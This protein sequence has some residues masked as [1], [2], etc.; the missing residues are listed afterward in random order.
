MNRKTLATAL[1][2]VKEQEYQQKLEVA[3]KELEKNNILLC[4]ALAERDDLQE[5]LKQEQKRPVSFKEY[6]QRR[7]R[8]KGKDDD[9]R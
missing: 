6:W 7:K 1:L 8:K 5:R 2:N 4:E 9:Y 3:V